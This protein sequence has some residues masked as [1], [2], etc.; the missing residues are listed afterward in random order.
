[1]FYSYFLS[2]ISSCKLILKIPLTLFGFRDQNYNGIPLEPCVRV[3]FDATW[4]VT[5]GELPFIDYWLDTKFKRI[6]SF[7][8]ME[9]F[10]ISIFV[11]LTFLSNG[12]IW[13]HLTPLIISYY[14]G[15]FRSPLCACSFSLLVYSY[16]Y[17]FL[18]L[19]I[20]L[21]CQKEW[22]LRTTNTIGAGRTGIYWTVFSMLSWKL[23]EWNIQAFII[24]ITQNKNYGIS[25]DTLSDN[26]V[27]SL[28]W[29]IYVQL[30]IYEVIF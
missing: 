30:F 22:T 14:M 23:N 29:S 18:N 24:I 15:F 4:Q 17:G 1:M 25:W 19:T 21:F 10:C 12:K 2:L 13:L 16:F 11:R 5:T 9:N 7:L 27:F 26:T 6:G 20:C 28:A 3:S 8:Q